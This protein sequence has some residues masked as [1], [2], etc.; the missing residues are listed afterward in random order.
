MPALTV[1]R[2]SD[3]AIVVDNPTVSRMHAELTPLGGGKFSLRDTD[4]AAGTFVRDGQLWR[5]VTKTHVTLR[6][7][8]KLGEVELSVADL[9]A[10]ATDPAIAAEIN[11]AGRAPDG[12]PKPR[13]GGKV[14]FERDPATG[15]IVEKR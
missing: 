14:R 10:R 3:C 13:D 9:I 7:R 11:E 4:S 5:K 12:N 8:V 2:R 15:Q 1:G 6:D